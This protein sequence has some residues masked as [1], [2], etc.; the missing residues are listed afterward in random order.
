MERCLGF[1]AREKM[2]RSGVLSAFTVCMAGK[3]RRYAE[4]ESHELREAQVRAVHYGGNCHPRADSSGVKNGFWGVQIVCNEGG[5]NLGLTAREDDL[6]WREFDAPNGLPLEFDTI[7]DVMLF[8]ELFRLE[9]HWPGTKDY[10]TKPP[11]KV[12]LSDKAL[13]MIEDS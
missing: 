6:V 11:S 13:K 3:A 9:H 4:G 8:C 7:E 5:A 12:K 2:T 10:R 1:Q